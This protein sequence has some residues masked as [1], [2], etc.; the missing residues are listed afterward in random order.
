MSIMDRAADRVIGC[1]R[2]A[3]SRYARTMGVNVRPAETA[4]IR[5]LADVLAD[6]FEDDP[7]MSWILP[8][9]AGRRARLARLFAAEVRCHHLAGGGVE[10][11]Q[12]DDGV[13]AGAALW[14]PPGRWKQSVW[15]FVRIFPA[16]V[17]ALGSR[18]M[19]GA[20]VDNALAKAHPEAPH[21]YLATIGTGASARG[22]GYGKALLNSRLT[23]CDRDRI[24]A[25][26]ESSKGE[27][28]PYYNRFGF[29]VTGELVMPG[30]GPTVYPMVR[31]PQ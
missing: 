7:L 16:L 29:E 21:W 26:L 5:V 9:A 27:N 23:R 15:A 31:E 20:E 28:I 24:P 12:G 17:R 10:V 18:A 30:G 13:I 2:T 3:G 1:G 22:G 19:V 25:Y 14:D 6:A 8:D 11:A 4:D